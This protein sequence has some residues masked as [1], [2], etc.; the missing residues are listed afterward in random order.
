[1]HPDITEAN[2]YGVEIPHSDGRAGCAAILFREEVKDEVGEEL[3]E[4]VA[5]HAFAG[6]PK[7]S[8]PVFL[9]KVGEVRVTGNMKQ[10]KAGLRGEGVDPGKLGGEKVFWL[11]GVRYVEFTREDWEELRGGRVK[12]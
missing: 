12:L 6:L 5:K 9:R 10:M 4:S 3:L 2:V 11:K 1:M 7:Y 8:V